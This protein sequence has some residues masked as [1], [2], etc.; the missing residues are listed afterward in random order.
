MKILHTSDWHLGKSLGGHPL[1]EDQRFALDKVKQHLTEQA[2]D[3]L[4]LSGDVFDRATPPSDAVRMFGHWL[5]DVH[6]IA[7]DLPIVVIAGNHDNGPRLAWTASVLDRQRVYLRGDTD[8]IEDPI[9]VTGRDGVEAEVWAL[10]FLL[11]GALGEATPSQV[12]AMDE[13][14]RRIRAR[15]TPGMAQL[16]V[17]HCFVR[18][19]AV[20]D[21]ERGIV[22]TATQIDPETF[23]GFDYVALGHLH[24]PQ[25]VG[26]NAR[27]AGSLARYSFSE[28]GHD[29]A[30]LAV[31]VAPGVPHR[32]VRHPLPCLRGMRRITASLEALRDDPAFDAAVDDYVELT[33]SPAVPAGNPLD[34]LRPRWR[35]ILSFRNDLGT[36]GAR[37]AL[38]NDGGEGP[39]DLEADFLSFEKQFP[40][41]DATPDELLAA[42]RSLHARVATR[43]TE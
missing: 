19:G 11:P 12:G 14:L 41:T 21:S 39:R 40:T 27:Y 34:L 37:V 3:L 8:R 15:W 2:Y 17:A 16:L 1:D 6:A 25:S 28:A 13:A 7:P 22:G 35:H 24:R 5:G 23:E 29:K 26:P 38:V 10:P 31:D 42:F 36:E 9:R 43:V 32:C 30:L 18:D 33:L 20:S 4:V